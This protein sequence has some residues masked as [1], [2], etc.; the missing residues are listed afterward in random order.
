[1]IRTG[2]EAFKY[3]GIC[4]PKDFILAVDFNSHQNLSSFKWILRTPAY[5]LLHREGC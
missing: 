4:L 5:P 3:Q 1:M 2:T